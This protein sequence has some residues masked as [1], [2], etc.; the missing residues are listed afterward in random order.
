MTS[1]K[2]D[3]LEA[4]VPARPAKPRKTG[5]TWVTLFGEGPRQVEAM[6]E[7]TGAFIDQAKL[8]YGSSLLSAPKTVQAITGLLRDAG[9]VAYP[10]GTILEM[11]IRAG[12]KDQFFDWVQQMGF[13]GIEV[14]DGVI[15]MPDELRA[16]CIRQGVEAGLTVTTVVQE[17]IRK[18][19]VEVVPLRERIARAK[20]DLDAGASKVHVVLQAMARGETPADIVGPIKREQVR[21]MIEAIG[22]EH[23]VWE[24]LSTDDQ[25]TYL[26][27]LGPDVNLGHV[28][29]RTVVQLEAQRR[30][31][32]YESFWSRVWGR[33]HWS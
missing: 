7:T 15:E 30:D 1:N 29:P 18:P 24:A 4:L 9:I 10:G 23:L 6:L 33:T 25:L 17:V 27:M 26:R 2:T 8:A 3:F 16:D 5:A 21:V 19:V 12:R 28:D 20:R 13:T 32:G 31:L 14:C 11:A 22:A